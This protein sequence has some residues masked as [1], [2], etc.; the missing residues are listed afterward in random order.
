VPAY[1]RAVKRLRIGSGAREAGAASVESQQVSENEETPPPEVGGFRF[2][3]PPH[4]EGGVYANIVSVYH[5][6][7]EFTFDWAVT[8]VAQ[9]ADPEDPDSPLIV[10]C[11]VTSRVRVPV[12]IIFEVLRAINEDMTAYEREWGE[13]R[14]P[15]RRAE[16]SEEEE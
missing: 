4:L 5:S 13:I 8:Q 15:E 6:G 10:P 16:P 12:T 11:A 7:Y 9:P 3:V 14:A 1:E 2:F